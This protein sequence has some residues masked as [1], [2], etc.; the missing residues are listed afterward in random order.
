M[1]GA[2]ERATVVMLASAL[3][4]T[5]QI[6]SR[7]DGPL[8]PR[9][10][11]GSPAGSYVLS[12]FDNVNLFTG[13]LNIALPLLTVGKRGAA[14]HT[15]TLVPDTT[16]WRVETRLDC[17]GN[18]VGGCT[19]YYRP[20]PD[21][22]TFD[23]PGYG[24]GVISGRTVDSVVDSC[25]GSNIGSWFTLSKLSYTDSALTETELRDALTQGTPSKK[26]D[27]SNLSG[28]PCNEY[29]ATDRGKVF[30]SYHRETVT[31]VSTDDIVDFDR[32]FPPTSPPP[33]DTVRIFPSVKRTPYFPDGREMVV[34]VG[35]VN[36]IQDRNA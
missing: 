36:T 1:R 18:T 27:D 6:S 20:K 14:Y 12:G 19:P 4:A 15:I 32:S 25:G 13:K 8:P 23:Q 17:S 30:S 31:F 35:K 9:S 16:R 34:A 33:D 29:G 28:V 7:T 24:A 2:F 21:W 3:W 22:W 11:P 26:R 10:V 5:A